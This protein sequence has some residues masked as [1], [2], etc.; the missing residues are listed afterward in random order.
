MNDRRQ[1]YRSFY[2]PKEPKKQI[3]GAAELLVLITSFLSY[4]KLKPEDWVALNKMIRQLEAHKNNISNK[5]L[6]ALRNR[7]Q[8]I[9]NQYQK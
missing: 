4:T 2:Y 6:R 1:N 7:F 9:Q 8:N 5:V 3:Q